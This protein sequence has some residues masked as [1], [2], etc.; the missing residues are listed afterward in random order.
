MLDH[1]SPKEDKA[2]QE[3]HP[4][5]TKG[6]TICRTGSQ[7]EEFVRNVG[8]YISGKSIELGWCCFLISAVTEQRMPPADGRE[9]EASCCGYY[10]W[11]GRE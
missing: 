2:F 1:R 11:G 5:R 6:N 4:A 8:S 10:A 9:S 3:A 7:L